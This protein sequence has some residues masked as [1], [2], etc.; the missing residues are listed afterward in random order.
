MNDALQKGIASG[1]LK[2]APKLGEMLAQAL[3]DK[4]IRVIDVVYYNKLVAKIKE[5]KATIAKQNS[6]IFELTCNQCPHADTDFGVI[7]D[8]YG[9]NHTCRTIAQLEG[10]A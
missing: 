4:G 3:K 9:D 10:K 8:E 5:Q 1:F 7:C 6:E 2:G